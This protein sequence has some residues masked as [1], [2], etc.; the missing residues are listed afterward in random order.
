MDP[1]DT[2]RIA[3]SVGAELG[4][5]TALCLLP[6]RQGEPY[7]AASAGAVPADCVWDLSFD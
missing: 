7:I 2:E 4:C 3:A 5:G 1:G 6:S